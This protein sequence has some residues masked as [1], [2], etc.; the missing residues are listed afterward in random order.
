MRLLQARLIACRSRTVA[1][2]WE[3]VAEETR[4]F[5][6]KAEALRALHERGA[7]KFLIAEECEKLGT[8]RDELWK[9]VRFLEDRIADELT[10][11]LEP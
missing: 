4:E 11:R 9:R 7:G 8:G 2:A 6:V 1:E 3:S 5:L 10:R